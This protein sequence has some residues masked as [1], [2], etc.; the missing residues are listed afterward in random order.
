ML[1]AFFRHLIRTFCTAN[2]LVWHHLPI[3]GSWGWKL[4]LGVLRGWLH[5]GVMA[6]LLGVW[7]SSG[8]ELATMDWSEEL[9]MILCECFLSYNINSPCVQAS[10][11]QDRRLYPHINVVRE[12]GYPCTKYRY[13][14]TQKC[15]AKRCHDI[16]RVKS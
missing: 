16:G 8:G 11:R 5:V 13:A 12:H 3:C 15:G 7:P 14:C 6:L 2:K 10:M 9:Y 1:H 4:L